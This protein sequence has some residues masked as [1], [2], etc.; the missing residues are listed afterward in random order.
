MVNLIGQTIELIDSINNKTAGRTTILKAAE[1]VWVLDNRQNQ[2]NVML[3]KDASYKL[4][5][6]NMADSDYT[7]RPLKL[8]KDFLVVKVV[9]RVGGRERR[10]YIRVGCEIPTLL[11]AGSVIEKGTILEIA[12]GS[13]TIQTKLKLNTED[14]VVVRISEMD[15]ETVLSCNVMTKK[16]DPDADEDDPWFEGYHYVVL[17]DEQTTEEKSMDLLYAK[18]YRLQKNVE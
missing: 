6:K 9:K 16:F 8:T 17:V 12:Y 11:T 10:R 1:D 3:H 13:L 7:A 14:P 5:I 15:G 4:S 18:I 2:L